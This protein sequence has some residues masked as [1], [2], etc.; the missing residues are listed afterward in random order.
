MPCAAAQYLGDPNSPSSLDLTAFP[1]RETLYHPHYIALSGF[2]WHLSSSPAR[3]SMAGMQELLG[4]PLNTPMSYDQSELENH[5]NP[6]QAGL[7]MT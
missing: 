5:T 1:T 2:L 7:L 3:R 4:V 6:I